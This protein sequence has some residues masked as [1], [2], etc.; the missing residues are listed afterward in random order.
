M[1]QPWWSTVAWRLPRTSPRS[2]SASFTT[3][4]PAG[5][6]SATAGSPISRIPKAS[7]RCCAIEWRRLAQHRGEA[8]GILEI[9]E[10]AVALGLPAGDDVV[11]LALL[12]LGDVLGKR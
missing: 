11:K 6:P 3:S 5:N 1:A 4:S 12:D 7:P 2:S 8:F 10:P 9:G